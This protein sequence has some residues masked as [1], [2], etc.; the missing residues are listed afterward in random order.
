MRMPTRT[1]F[2]IYIA[3]LEFMN[4]SVSPKFAV[5]SRLARTGC[6]EVRNVRDG[7]VR[8]SMNNGAKCCFRTLSM[9]VR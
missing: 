2:Q 8:S 4:Y 5:H 1:D 9:I 7:L 6:P 3:R